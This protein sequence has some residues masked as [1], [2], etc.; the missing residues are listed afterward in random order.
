MG[1]MA[2]WRDMQCSPSRAKGFIDLDILTGTGSLAKTLA[3]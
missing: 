2:V 3:V 1:I